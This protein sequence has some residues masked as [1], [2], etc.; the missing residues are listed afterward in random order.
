MPYT[1]KL[2][3]RSLLRS[4]GFALLAVAI[5]ALGVGATTAMFSI[6]HTVLLK[7]LAYRD[8]G[9]LATLLF[10]VPQFSKELS[11]IPVNAQHYLLWRDHS[12]TLQEIGLVR[13]DSHILSGLGQAEQVKGALTTTNF[14]NLL[15]VSPR[16]GR[17]FSEGENQ[18]GH[19]HVI[20]VS[21]QFWQHRLSGRR[22]ALGRKILLDGRPYEVIGIMPPAFPFPRGHQLSELEQLPEQVDY[23]SPIVFSKDD[24]ATPVG[25][26]NY[27]AIG[28]LKPGTTISQVVADLTALETSFSK[29]YPEPVQ[30]V[31]VVRPLQQ[32]MA[33][34]VRLPLLILMAAVVAV[35]LIVCINLMNLM[36]VRSIAQRRDWAIRL[37]IG[38]HVRDLL[39]TAFLESLLLSV[40]GGVMGS[41]LAFWLLRLVRL[42]APFDLPRIDELSID[43]TALLFALG[44]SV[45]TALLFGIW[46]AWR[47]SR[48]DPR[49]ALQAS[50]RTA[51]GGRRGHRSGRILVAAEVTLST[52]LLLSAGLLLRSFVTVLGVNPGLDIQH[53]LTVRI[54]LPPEQY[55]NDVNVSSFYRRL[56]Q[57]VNALPGVQGTGLVSD[58]PVTGNNNNNPATAADRPIPPV[59]Q[60]PMTN[61]RYASGDYFK[62]AGIPLKEGRSLEERAGDTGE[63][64]ISENLA[65]RLWPSQSAVGRL[66]KIYGN[67]RVQSVVGVVGAVRGVSLTEDPTMMIYFSNWNHF[68]RDMA[69]VVR[70]Q[71]E[72]ERLAS[73]IRGIVGDLDSQATTPSIQTMEQVVAKSLAPRRFQLVLLVGFAVVALLL[74]CMGIYGVLAFAT[75]RRTS[76][77]GIRMALGARPAQ[78][79]ESTLR[80][81]MAPVLAGLIAG[82]CLS[83]A[84]AR[85]FQ[86]L[87]FQVR[88]LDPVIYAAASGAMVAASVL[89][90]FLPAR[91]A[92]SLSPL[93]ALRYE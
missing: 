63:V 71:Q 27:L 18:P 43:P 4:P 36:M 35:L 58:I 37:A 93:E 66:L 29:T 17:G 11:T 77:I 38:A 7:P 88:A 10:R 75:R 91:R 50:G 68:A 49:E 48:I 56:L 45:A 51:T 6:T 26:E 3:V 84:F 13:P 92:A 89:A 2:A 16:L 32:A 12:R 24:L 72:P 65:A 44:A 81:G 60:W 67:P 41:L 59:T 34:E 42:K 52:V 55:R 20:I 85:V 9:S 28:R 73:T 62:T 15:G 19:N 70:T 31:I 80:N 76:E 23:W 57:R 33:R 14:F 40:A 25:N 5:I 8:P 64:L 61:W 87:L 90:C 79:L 1:V 30:F 82:I 21:Y 46:P 83:A 74:S 69:L 78:V 86:S 22:N 53:L 47:A 54:N 39:Q